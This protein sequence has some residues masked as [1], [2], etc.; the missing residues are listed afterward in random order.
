MKARSPSALR[1]A[2]ARDTRAGSLAGGNSPGQLTPR[3]ELG[4]ASAPSTSSGSERPVLIASARSAWLRDVVIGTPIAGTYR[5]SDDTYPSS[6]GCLR[7]RPGRG[8]A[9]RPAEAAAGC[10]TSK[11]SVAQWAGRR[12]RP[13]PGTGSAGSMCRG[14]R[15]RPPPGTASAGSMCGGRR[16]RPPRRGLGGLHRRR[17]RQ[18]AS[19][20]LNRP[21]AVRPRRRQIW[22][23]YVECGRPGSPSAR[24]CAQAGQLQLPKVRTRSSCRT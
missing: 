10:G 12:H 19:E 9:S 23:F 20:R 5:L 1:A 11:G 24:S 22:P 13:S 7:N 6:V 3:S 14:R 21:T 2:L 16:S 8:S 15:R 17:S 18:P 4:S